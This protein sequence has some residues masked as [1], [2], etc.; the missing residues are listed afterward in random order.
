[1]VFRI[2][3]WPDL[4]VRVVVV[5]PLIGR[6]L[7]IALGRVL[8]LL[9]ATQGSD[10]EIAPGAPHR[11][12]AAGID[13]VGAEDSI[14]VANEGVGPDK[15]SFLNFSQSPARRFGASSF[16][17]GRTTQSKLAFSA[18]RSSRIAQ[19]CATSNGMLIGWR[20]YVRS[21]SL[22]LFTRSESYWK[23]HSSTIR[24]P[25]RVTRNDKPLMSRSVSSKPSWKVSAQLPRP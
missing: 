5:P 15:F 13:E 3:H 25:V 14:A 23:K 6:G 1:M 2:V 4:T 7:R 16:Y 11:L 12:V 8:P 9:L 17:C 22:H 21:S 10:V 20:N 18:A 19:S 24:T